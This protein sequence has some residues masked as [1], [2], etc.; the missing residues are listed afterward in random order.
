MKLLKSVLDRQIAF[1]S[2]CKANNWSIAY[3]ENLEKTLKQDTQ[4]TKTCM[5]MI[6][7]KC[8]KPQKV[9]IKSILDHKNWCRSCCQCKQYE[10]DDLRTLA[11]ERMGMHKRSSMESMF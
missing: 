3:I 10:I 2:A 1:Q 8:T 6:C 4:W 7:N 9:A 5:Y 11:R